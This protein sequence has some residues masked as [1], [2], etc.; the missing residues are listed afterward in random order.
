M[1]EKGVT[2]LVSVIIPCYNAAPYL[3]ETIESALKQ[4]YPQLE[5]IV[6]DDGST[7]SSSQIIESF[8][9]YANFVPLRQPNSGVSAARNMGIQQARGEFI[10]FLDA[11]DWM[12]PD[13]ISRKV[14]MLISTQTDVAY[15]RVEVCNEKLKPEYIADGADPANFDNEVFYFTPSP[16]HSPSSAVVK[17]SALDQAGFFDTSLS[18]SADLDIWIRLSF[19]H[20]FARVNEPLVKYRLVPGSMNT[21]IAV[22]IRDMEYI[23]SKYGRYRNLHSKLKRLKKAFYYSIIGNAYYRKNPWQLIKYSF[24][25]LGTIISY[26]KRKN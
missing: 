25:Y 12:Y 6:V 22:Q 5:V 17:R 11:D 2:G 20:R 4:S 15:S 21:N 14:D 7:D 24:K 9:H 8:S 10:A 16:I 19:G 1:Q 18:T 3:A 26:G 13:N 23:F